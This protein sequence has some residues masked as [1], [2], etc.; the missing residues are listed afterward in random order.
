MAE[1][2][3]HMPHTVR[4]LSQFS[5]AEV[6]TL[7][8]TGR[9][10]FKNSGM[11]VL[12]AP[13]SKE[14]GRILVVTSRKVGSSPARNLIR[15]RLKALFYEEQWF[16]LPYD[17]IFIIRTPATDYSYQKLKALCT[18]FVTSLLKR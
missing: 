1:S 13:R 17:F 5:T 2:I 15:R 8:D 6:R 10:A 14:Y 16:N 11:T 12:Y 9:L 4:A 18:G 7:F 3:A